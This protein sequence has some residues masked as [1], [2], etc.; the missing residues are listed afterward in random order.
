[1]DKEKL[2]KIADEICDNQHGCKH[3]PIQLSNGNCW[4]ATHNLTK[5]LPKELK[6]YVD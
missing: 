6:K 2:L 3:C 5:E 4:I 1:M